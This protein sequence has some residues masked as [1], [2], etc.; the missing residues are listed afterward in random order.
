MGRAPQIAAVQSRLRS[1]RLLTL[2]G[3]G[4]TGKTRLALQ[5][6]AGSFNDFEHGVWLVELA[7][8]AD[9]VQLPQAVAR[10]LGLRAQAADLFETSPIDDR[11]RDG[12]TLVIEHLHDKN[13]L[14]ILDNC[15]HLVQACADLAERLLR[16]APRLQILTTSREPLGVVGETSYPVP[17]LSL[18][19][20]VQPP[21]ETLAQSEAVLLFVER[22]TAV[23][24]DFALT[25]QN[26]PAVAQICRRLDGI[27]LA[28]ELG[29]ARA[30][31]LTAEQIAARLHQR[32]ALLAGG[33]RTAPPRQ[34]TL[35][36]AIDWS[37]DL[38]SGA[39][40]SLLRA[41]SVFAGGWA[42]E[43]AEQM[44]RAPE[45]LELLTQLVTKSLVL[46]EQPSGQEGRF[47]M[48]E[49]IRDY[50]QE[51]LAQAGEL[52]AVQNRHLA[53]YVTMAEAAELGLRR[54]RQVHW[55]NRLDRERDNVRA[56]LTWAVKSNEAD[57]A[58]RLAGALT[59]YWRIR[60]YRLEGYRWLKAALELPT[61]VVA[62]GPNLWRAK[63]L[64][65][66]SWLG[67]VDGPSGNQ[68]WLEEALAMY[69][70][71][72]DKWGTA[73]AM[74]LLAEQQLSTHSL[75]EVQQQFEEALDLWLAAK[76]SWGVGFCL[77]FMGHL[78][79][80]MGDGAKARELYQRSVETLRTVGD[81]WQL[82][83][84]LGD[85]ARL[86]WLE[87]DAARARTALEENLTVFEALGDSGVIMSLNLLANISI[88]AG[89][90]SQARARALTIQ[91]LPGSPYNFANGQV[92]LGQIA[93]RQGRLIE[94]QAELEAAFQTYS[95]LNNGGGI[96]W[97][98]PWLA[99]V[100][101][102]QG[103]LERAKALLPADRTLTGRYQD[104]AAMGF[105]L[106]VQGDIAR[107]QGQAAAALESYTRS[108]QVLVKH[109]NQPGIADRLDAFATLAAA[110]HQPERA[111][112]LFGAAAALRARI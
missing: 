108:L 8:L 28:I 83:R 63:A 76:D 112:R 92:F 49:T 100:A 36:S 12:L 88:E 86:A 111:A 94:A 109:R 35:R 69:R 98:Q 81:A 65:G 17:A 107:A 44:T 59:Y 56:A 4:G 54:P 27:P 20:S 14:L 9:P 25:E 68:P 97:V 53:Y 79:E 42:L 58:I 89:D 7:P 110:A 66:A 102:H 103:D 73:R 32:F 50:M 77:H 64:L 48:L 29:A 96:G 72:G 80:N 101:Y 30:R 67:E 43:A 24:S 104:G 60:E 55:L 52:E 39:E 90:Y 26:A 1:T 51:K 19:D 82:M 40:R 106:L 15:E 3:P 18:P 38:L 13:L 105:T 84:P 78:A 85:L 46:S 16:A 23:R 91:R 74:A 41:L 95:G 93:F 31:A 22:A 57:L 61:R 33:N 11:G 47:R 6:A 62:S 5:I 37:Y 75:A 70:E 71:L 21:L 2:T 87:G 34:Q 45:G 99:W 10:A